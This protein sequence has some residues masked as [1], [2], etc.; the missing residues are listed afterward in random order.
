MFNLRRLEERIVL[1]GAAVIDA[2][3]EFQ[4][5]DAHDAEMQMYAME[6]S[7]AADWDYGFDGDPGADA[8][9]PEADNYEVNVLVISSDI[10]DSDDLAAAARDGVIP[11]RN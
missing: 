7:N 5:Q 10:S 4:Q 3:D 1:D 9:A 2:M 8:E 11:P 6:D